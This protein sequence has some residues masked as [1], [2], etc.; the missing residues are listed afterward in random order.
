MTVLASDIADYFPEFE[1]LSETV[2][3]RWLDQAQRRVNYTQWGDKADD[4][5][6]WLTAHLL[7]ITQ[8]LG[9]GTS[10]GSGAIGSKKVGDLAVTYKVPDRMSQ[11]FLAS[12]AYGQYY[13]TLKTGVWPER[14]LGGPCETCS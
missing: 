13:L 3:N 12:T 1:G 5:V 7:A 11:S 14:V 6:I 4:A 10:P 9:C 2:I 8:S